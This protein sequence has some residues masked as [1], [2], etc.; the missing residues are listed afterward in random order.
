MIHISIILIFLKFVGHTIADFIGCYCSLYSLIFYKKANFF[1]TCEK[2]R[3]S[4]SRNTT[5]IFYFLLTVTESPPTTFLILYIYLSF[6]LKRLSQLLFSK[7]FASIKFNWV[8]NTYYFVI[9]NVSMTYIFVSHIA[10]Y[11]WGF[12]FGLTLNLEN[13]QL[14]IF[15]NSFICTNIIFWVTTLYFIIILYRKHVT[16]HYILWLFRTVYK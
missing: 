10:M 8:T 13:F 6:S 7:H 15:N 14:K 16:L 11:S 5:V 3:I 2:L 1:L 4:K 12:V 9:Y